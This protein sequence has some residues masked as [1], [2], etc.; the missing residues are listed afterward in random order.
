MKRK[1]NNT[2]K[3]RVAKIKRVST[4]LQFGIIGTAGLVQM[5]VKNAIAERIV[6]ME[7]LSHLSWAPERLNYLTTTRL[8]L[9]LFILGVVLVSLGFVSDRKQVLIKK[10]LR[11]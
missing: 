7:D 2:M 4:F 3:N 10:A 1:N 6:A 8:L 5:L 9:T 11:A